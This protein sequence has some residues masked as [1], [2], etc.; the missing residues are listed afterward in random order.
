MRSK[1]ENAPRAAIIFRRSPD[2]GCIRD[3]CARQSRVLWGVTFREVPEGSNFP[4]IEK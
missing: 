4:G 3:A 1:K 2:A